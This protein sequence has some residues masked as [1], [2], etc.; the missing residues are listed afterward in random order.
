MISKNKIK[1]TVIV[2]LLTSLL[3]PTISTAAMMAP[4]ANTKCT[5][6][7][8]VVDTGKNTFI[9]LPNANETITWSKALPTAKKAKTSK[10]EVSMSWVKADPELNMMKMTG[11]FGVISNPTSSPIRVIG[12]FTSIS[13]MLG[14]HEMAMKDGAM[15]MREKIG[16]FVIPANSNYS[17]KP[18]GNHIMLMGLTEDVEAGKLY[19]VT[20]I[21]S[22]GDRVTFK[23][24][25]R[26]F[27]GANESYDPG[28]GDS[29]KPAMPAG[30]MSNS[31]G[32]TNTG[33]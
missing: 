5:M 22:T 17:L 13:T 33:N 14:T 3:F 31:M 4:K 28:T 2:G 10:L 16:G 18:G 26:V 21:T 7:G 1:A 30:G 24:L 25:G 6:T 12:G 15:V 27:N 19:K 23:T 9:C 8:A 20:L 32:S 29:L 11:S